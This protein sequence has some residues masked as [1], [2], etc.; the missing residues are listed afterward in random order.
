MANYTIAIC[1]T[2]L[3]EIIGKDTFESRRDFDDACHIPG[4]VIMDMKWVDEPDGPTLT[5]YV[6][7][8]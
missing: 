5:A 2:V 4:R 6:E 1:D 7:D 8:N 3:E